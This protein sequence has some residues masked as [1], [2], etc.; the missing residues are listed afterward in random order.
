MIQQFLKL[1]L[2]FHLSGRK[3][4][5]LCHGGPLTQTSRELIWQINENCLLKNEIYLNWRKQV[6]GEHHT[7]IGFRLYLPASNARARSSRFH[8]LCCW[9]EP[10][11]RS[12]GTVP[13]GRAFGFIWITKGPPPAHTPPSTIS[14]LFLVG[15]IY[16]ASTHRTHSLQTDR[17]TQASDC[18]KSVGCAAFRH[19]RKF[20]SS[21]LGGD[22]GG[23]PL[24]TLI[25]CL[26]LWGYL[27]TRLPTAWTGILLLCAAQRSAYQGDENLKLG[28]KRLIV[29][30]L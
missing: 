25:L 30:F 29:E 19:T 7:D 28:G 23:E 11:P 16:D 8:F 10:Q 9:S 18:Q 22:G 17:Q 15:C 27:F 20:V 13:H 6:D 12:R 5:F 3:K 26:K 1:P 14:S 2:R 21:N 24:F 4:A